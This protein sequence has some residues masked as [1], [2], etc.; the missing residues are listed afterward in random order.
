MYQPPGM[1]ARL[2][3]CCSTQCTLMW[4]LPPDGGHVPWLVGSSRGRL[5]SCGWPPYWIRMQGLLRPCLAACSGTGSSCSGQS[6]YQDCM[7]GLLRPW[8]VAS[9][10]AGS[11]CSGWSPYQDCMQGVLQPCWVASPRACS[12]SRR[13]SG[14]KAS[15]SEGKECFLIATLP[16]PGLYAGAIAAIPA[17]CSGGRANCKPAAWP[18]A[19]VRWLPRTPAL[20]QSQSLMRTLL[21]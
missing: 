19:C 21:L 7:Q 11:S 4:R 9:S 2:K 12:S 6:P 18:W 13:D 14:Y 8:L 16:L 20:M 10:G 3:G 15:L 5:S 1:M 17:T